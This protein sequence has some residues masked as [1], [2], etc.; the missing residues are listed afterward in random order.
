MTR[1]FA[2]VFAAL[3]VIACSVAP[4]DT[5]QAGFDLDNFMDKQK[6]WATQGFAGYSFVQ[7]YTQI[8]YPP[9]N[10][11]ANVT[12]KNNAIYDIE[13]LGMENLYLDPNYPQH[14]EKLKSDYDEY[15]EGRVNSFGT[16]SGIYEW[17][18]S[19]H[20]GAAA[21]LGK[22][23]KLHFKISYNSEYHY[24]EYVEFCVYTYGHA[25]NNSW[26]AALGQA[27]TILE[28]SDFHTLP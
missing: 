19:W 28:L 24:P 25:G 26:S 17:L 6:A 20:E 18:L 10:Y 14:H 3:L 5:E 23:Q 21:N 2:A 12:I 11:C 22:R 13:N 7:K 1:M 27:P 16:I 15:I 8:N 4:N 9:D